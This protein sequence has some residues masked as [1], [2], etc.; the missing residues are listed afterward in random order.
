MFCKQHAEE[1]MVDVQSKRNVEG[2]KTPMYCKQH[3]EE[4]V[5]DVQSKCCSH[6]S[7]KKQSSFN[8]EGSKTPTYCMNHDE[9]GWNGGRPE[10][11][12]RT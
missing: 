12:L 2:S 8:V 10:Q 9:N 11:A 4:S 3:A 7:C 6:D 5:V 1:G